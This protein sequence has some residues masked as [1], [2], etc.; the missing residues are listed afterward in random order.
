MREAKSASLRLLISEG[1]CFNSDCKPRSDEHLQESLPPVD[2]TVYN[3][4]NDQAVIRIQPMRRLESAHVSPRE[5]TY[6]HLHESDKEDMN[7]SYDHA[8][9]VRFSCV[10]E[11]GYRVLTRVGNN[12]REV[13]T[14]ATDDVPSH[15]VW[16]IIRLRHELTLHAEFGQDK[17][18]SFREDENAQML[19]Q[20]ERRKRIAIG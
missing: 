19:K 18:S 1:N 4:I 12:N 17:P 15:L 8:R 6:S 9:P 5:E 7:E 13:Q 11:D 3:E 16:R 20:S 2:E 14:T 10:R